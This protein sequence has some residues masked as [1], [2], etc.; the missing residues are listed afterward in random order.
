MDLESK[1][2]R[3]IEIERKLNDESDD[4]D[5]S[6]YFKKHL[7]ELRLK[8]ET[9]FSEFQDTV[10]ALTVRIYFIFYNFTIG[11]KNFFKLNIQGQHQ[12][13]L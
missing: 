13:L 10:S 7:N 11:K 4:K 9:L 5:H 3:I 1:R 12:F 8:I 6:R 2:V